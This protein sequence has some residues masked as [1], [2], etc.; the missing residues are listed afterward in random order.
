MPR[1]YNHRIYGLNDSQ[2]QFCTFA[3]NILEEE[4]KQ[5]TEKMRGRI[6]LHDSYNVLK[7]NDCVCRNIQR[8][9]LQ[10]LRNSTFIL[11]SFGPYVSTHLFHDRESLT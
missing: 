11:Y 6:L 5:K 2:P 7:V 8:F 4:A 10:A 3:F 1:A 9:S